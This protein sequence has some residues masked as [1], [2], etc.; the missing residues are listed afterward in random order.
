MELDYRGWRSSWSQFLME[1]DYRGWRSSWSQFLTEL[2]YRGPYRDEDQSWEDRNHHSYRG[3]DLDRHSRERTSGSNSR[4]IRW[5]WFLAE[6]KFHLIPV[7]LGP[8]SLGVGLAQTV[9]LELVLRSTGLL[10]KV[11]QLESVPHSTGLLWT[12]AISGSIYSDF[13]PD[14]SRFGP[15]SLEVWSGHWS[16][17][18]D[19][20]A[21]DAV[22]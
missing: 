5:I 10:W 16:Q 22:G 2:D 15:A 12:E 11:V 18:Q 20:T 21:R 7:L 6:L 1:L 13:T 3:S 17:C 9:K 19:V 14:F 8:A 4:G